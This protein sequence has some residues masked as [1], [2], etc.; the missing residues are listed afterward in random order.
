MIE[1]RDFYSGVVDFHVLWDVTMYRL[2]KS[3]VSFEEC[4]SVYI[5]K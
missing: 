4:Y 5:S 2:I 1:T 3:Y